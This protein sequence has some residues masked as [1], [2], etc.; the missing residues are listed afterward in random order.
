M[1]RLELSVSSEHDGQRV[2]RF[3]AEACE[4]SRTWA[5]GIIAS[6]GVTRQGRPVKKNERVEIG[7]TL[8][9]EWRDKKHPEVIACDAPELQILH[10]DDDIVVVAKPAGV[11][12]H[13]SYGWD[14][15]TVLG[16]LAARG[17]RTATSG[18]AERQGIV[19]RLDQGTS[20]AMVVAKGEYAYSELKRQFKEREVEKIYHAVVQGHPDPTAGTVEGP[21][22]RDPHHE[23]KFAVVTGGKPSVTHYDTLEAFRYATLLEIHLETGRTHQIRVH[24]SAQRHPCVG[25]DMY[26]ADPTLSAALGLSRQWL[27][28]AELEFTHPTTAERVRFEAPYPEELETALDRLATGE[29]M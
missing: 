19:H 3:L 29:A 16:V 7:Q 15:P 5:A 17:V 10:E 25:D 26:G 14:G 22:G 9:V 12:A 20:G 28:A 21:I 24:M 11:A 8:Q 13:P 18:A 6:G 23:W 27:H 2:D 4:S 1:N